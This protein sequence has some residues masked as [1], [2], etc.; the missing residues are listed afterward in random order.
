VG[1]LVITFAGIV[2]Q[3]GRD[4]PGSGAPPGWSYNPSGWI[5]RLAIVFLALVGFFLA[6]YM[7]AFQ[8]GHIVSP[9]DPIFGESTERV[10]TSD[11]SKAFPVSDAGLGALSYLLDALAGVIGGVRRWRTMPWMVVLFGFLI[12]PPGVTSIVLVIL[13][14]VGIGHW[15]TLCLVASVVMLLMV[16]PALDEV[17]ATAQFLRRE[18]RAGRNLWHVFWC[19]ESGPVEEPKVAS[20][21]LRSEI[22]HSVEAFSAPWNLW[23]STIVGVWLMA[24]PTLLHLVGEAA[25]STHIVGAL[26]VTFSVV[27]FAEPARVTR[28]PN[29]ILG[30]W[31]LLAAWILD[32]GMSV[33][34][35]ISVA[36]GIALIVLNLRRGPINDRYG[37]WHSVIY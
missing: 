6:R 33:W 18:R 12:I 3:L 26:V 10:L 34:P 31:L 24:A 11:V 28:F 9:W 25:D 20:R 23:L 30:F 36:S 37:S 13:Q 27:A 19:G 32:G 15:C 4:G 14:P 16:S 35:W 1:A 7:A 2:P 21:S 22:L 17:V 29:I 8:L 5:Q